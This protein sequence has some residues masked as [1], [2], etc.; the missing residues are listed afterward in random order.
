MVS[1]SVGKSFVQILPTWANWVKIFTFRANRAKHLPVCSVGLLPFGLIA[2]T[3]VPVEQ[4]AG[5]ACASVRPIR[6]EKV[7]FSVFNR[8]F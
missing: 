8:S 3:A 2:A 5:Q 4:P 6:Y 7:P 1:N